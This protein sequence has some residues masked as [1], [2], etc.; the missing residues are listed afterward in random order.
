MMI[1]TPGSPSLPGSPFAPIKP[2]G[3]GSPTSPLV[4]IIII[5]IM[6]FAGVGKGR[7]NHHLYNPPTLCQVTFSP[8]RNDGDN[9]H[10]HGDADEDCNHQGKT[11]YEKVENH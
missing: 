6:V 9:D 4:I 11:N 5:I 7:A 1:V 10:D 8:Q 3:P 2:S